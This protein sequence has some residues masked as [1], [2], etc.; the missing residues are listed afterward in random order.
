MLTC[1]CLPLWK[2]ASELNVRQGLLTELL[3]AGHVDAHHHGGAP[4]VTRTSVDDL[5]WQL[6]LA[7][8]SG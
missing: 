7:Q 6:A 2:A 4:R 3:S 8:A 5:R 1:D